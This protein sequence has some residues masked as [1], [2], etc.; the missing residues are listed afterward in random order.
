MLSGRRIILGVTGGIAAYK[1]AELARKLVGAGC[2]VTAVMTANACRFI[3]PLTL[4]TLTGR[5][6]ATELFAD[7]DTPLPHISLACW[8]ELVLV[9]PATADALART[10]QGRAEDLLSALI[11]DTAAPVLWAPAMNTRMWRHPLTQD[12][13][14]RLAAAGHHFV[15]PAAGEL[16]CGEEGE[17]RLAPLQDIMA[18]ARELLAPSGPLNG[19]RILITAGPTREPWDA[20]RFLSNRSTGRMGY[21]LAAEAR[22]RGAQ[23]TLVSGP[24]ELAPP[25]G[26]EVVRV[27]TAREMQTA[28]MERFPRADIVIAA[29]AVADFRPAS[30]AEAK[31]KKDA[32]PSAIALAPN[33]DILAEMG[34]IKTSQIL[35]G[36]AAESSGDLAQ[37]GQAKLAAK[38]LDLIVANRAGG[39]QDAF[40]AEASAA[41]L[42]A[43]DGDI[44]DLARRSKPELAAAILDRVAALADA[45][46]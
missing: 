36:F 38:R 24:V 31:L 43:A 21:A 18:A 19:K 14:R 6:V 30:P 3:G 13:I 17:G 5:P 15:R 42:V 39:E 34:R 29:A 45:R 10:A 27:V 8:A 35:V 37:A 28:A 33:P 9:V 20:I 32:M 40:G 11:L 22:R 26:V 12:N 1:A 25:E 46:R 41:V 4:R 23:V 44:Q 2:E 16:A 7:P